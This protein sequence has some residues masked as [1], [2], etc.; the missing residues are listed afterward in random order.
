[1]HSYN[2]MRVSLSK[3]FALTRL[4]GSVCTAITSPPA[5]ANGAGVAATSTASADP[6]VGKGSQIYQAQSCN[7]CHGDLSADDLKALVAYLEGL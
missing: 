3:R 7:G 4:I 6:L 2:A 5:R 1:M